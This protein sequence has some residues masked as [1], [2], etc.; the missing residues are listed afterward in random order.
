MSGRRGE[1]QFSTSASKS[2]AAGHAQTPTKFSK[3]MPGKVKPY[4]IADD[5]YVESTHVDNVGHHRLLT[6]LFPVDGQDLNA[7][8][9]ESV[10][11][12]LPQQ[13]G[14]TCSSPESRKCNGP[15][16]YCS[17]ISTA[18]TCVASITERAYQ[19]DS[20][21][22]VGHATCTTTPAVS[23]LAAHAVRRSTAEPQQTAA[24]GP[25]DDSSAP[26]TK[27][28]GNSR[29]TPVSTPTTTL[30][31]AEMDFQKSRTLGKL[32]DTGWEP[33]AV[34]EN[35]ARLRAH[36]EKFGI[37]VRTVSAGNIRDDA[38][39]PAHR[40]VSM[41]LHV[42]NP[43]GTRGLARRQ[44]TS[45]YKVAPLKKVARQLLGYP[46]PKRVP[47]GVF[48]EQAI[49]I[50]TDEFIRAKDSGVKYL[51]NVFPLIELGWDRTRCVD[52]LA[53]RGFAETVKSACIGCPFH[54][55]AGWRWIRDNDPDGWAEAVAF[56]K[57]IRDGYPHATTQGQ[58]L[59]GQ[60]FL[61]RSCRPLDKVDLDPP[62]TTKRHLRP[63]TTSAEQDDPD[64]CSPWSCRSGTSVD[65]P[66]A[67]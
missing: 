56:D 8:A 18:T 64:G 46:H 37:P 19:R 9:G 24:S 49:G 2:G 40:F 33:R 32:A 61:H 28:R 42:L 22:R 45:E 60:Y 15:V 50:S 34:Y 26:V 27:S 43:D 44:C 55:N 14:R 13:T 10:V 29:A 12:Q 23:S 66:R 59:R 58:R 51:R 39:D 36:A 62:A 20:A 30:E 35:L 65:Q 5:R 63:V 57:A 38:L 16:H 41:P 48:V 11:Q 53:E 31:F 52:Y 17:R 25:Q 7:T 3:S 47:R 21:S 54:G 6:I 4:G 67:A 1:D